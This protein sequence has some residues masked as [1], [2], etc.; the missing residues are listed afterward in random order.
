MQVKNQTGVMSNEKKKDFAEESPKTRR[1]REK[2]KKHLDAFEGKITP[3][4]LQKKA[5]EIHRWISR[6]A[7]DRIVLKSKTISLFDENKNAAEIS[8]KIS[9]LTEQIQSWKMDTKIT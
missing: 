9:K 4:A 3:Q 2:L 5:I 8:Q 6:H 7:A 1:A